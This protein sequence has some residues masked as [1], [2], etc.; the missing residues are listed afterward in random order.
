[1]QIMSFD[2][3]RFASLYRT[4]TFARDLSKTMVENTLLRFAYWSNLRILDCVKNMNFFVT[5]ISKTNNLFS[6][7]QICFY[8]LFAIVYLF[9]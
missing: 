2:Y 3:N 1:M 7:S 8:G 5:Y 4:H 9:I 6:F